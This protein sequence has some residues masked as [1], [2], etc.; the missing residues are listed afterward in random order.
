MDLPGYW[1]LVGNITK[2]QVAHFTNHQL[3]AQPPKQGTKLPIGYLQK[4][5]ENLQFLCFLTIFL[6]LVNILPFFMWEVC[7]SIASLI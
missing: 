4:E 3:A 7:I 5:I 2:S 1:V 6:F